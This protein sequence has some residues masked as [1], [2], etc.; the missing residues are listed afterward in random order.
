MRLLVFSPFSSW[1]VHGQVEAYI[2]KA[3]EIRGVEVLV[4]TCDG[5][6]QPCSS[7]RGR[8]NCAA[9]G[10]AGENLFVNVFHLPL[11]RLGEFIA[12]DDRERAEAWLA[13]LI[14]EKY[15]QAHFD[16]LPVGAWARPGVLTHIRT[17]TASLSEPGVRETYRAFLGD[18]LIT[19]WAMERIIADFNPDAAILFN[20]RFHPHRAAF[21]ALRRHGRDVIVHERGNIAGSFAFLDNQTVLTWRHY[22]DVYET[23]RDVALS[24]EM[25]RRVDEIMAGRI[26]GRSMGYPSFYSNP[27]AAADVYERLG[28]PHGAPIVGVFTSSQ[29]ELAAWDDYDGAEDQLSMLDSLFEIYRDRQVYLVI[30]HHPFIAGAINGVAEAEVLSRY[31]SQALRAPANVRVVM[32]TEQLTS[33]AL[34]PYLEYAIAPF[35]S[36]A[37]ELLAAGVPTASMSAM[38]FAPV[39]PFPMESL[40]PEA[41]RALCGRL[42]AEARFPLP[43]PWFRQAHRFIHTMYLGLSYTFSGI[44][45]RDYYNPEIRIKTVSDLLPGRD[46]TLDRICDRI[47]RKAPLY[48]QPD[49]ADL[50]RSAD[51]EQSFL[52]A[53]LQML[54]DRRSLVRAAP[55]AGAGQ[56]APAVA[57]IHAARISEPRASSQRIAGDWL[58]R[59]RH[60]SVSPSRLM[61]AAEPV[62]AKS[63]RAA[64]T[65]ASESPYALI[66]GDGV[67]HEEHTLSIA[68]ALL[69]AAGP[70][71]DAIAFGAWIADG[72]RIRHRLI[73]GAMA[74][75]APATALAQ[76][77]FLA[78]PLALLS[79]SVWRRPALE[80]LLAE[81]E[82]LTPEAFAKLLLTTV[83]GSTRVHLLEET[84]GLLDIT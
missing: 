47:L 32:P 84:A 27:S 69:E 49:A 71:L 75:A 19:Y 42:E 55:P 74:G 7:T 66:Y 15:V 50:A 51:A 46:V 1:L 33:Y 18:T 67:Q 5:L 28:I 3:L 31:H 54:E 59:T 25:V 44:G 80:A 30:R 78:D 58:A 35:S 34:F 81:A 22:R 77:P 10:Q 23:W 65:A 62:T 79:L 26:S 52:E 72:G 57:V 29:D 53:K 73:L 13:D 60:R 4:V 43:L 36:I 82:N 48:P 45:V 83:T 12:N 56:A 41:L 16:D 61:I 76:H 2:A 24:D 40:T 63:L 20:G 11:R 70:S 6:Y 39:V 64:L 37:V 38:P 14:P 21:E 17:T 9:C 8:Q 68:T